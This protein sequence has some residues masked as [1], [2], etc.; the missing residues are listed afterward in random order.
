M[1]TKFTR[2]CVRWTLIVLSGGLGG[3][4]LVGLL[5]AAIFPRRG[6]DFGWLV[7][8][9]LL[10]GTIFVAPLLTIAYQ[11]FI[12]CFQPAI[13]LLA[14]MTGLLVFGLI[15]DFQ[16]R[17]TFLNWLSEITHQPATPSEQAPFFAGVLIIEILV[18]YA[19]YHGC[20][21]LGKRYLMEPPTSGMSAA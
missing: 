12:R 15:G 2:E 8:D 13:E 20:K 10:M 11:L 1:P 17:I 19:A 9:G 4:L 16:R 6:A 14:L 21:W 5:S 7:F 18:T 3:C